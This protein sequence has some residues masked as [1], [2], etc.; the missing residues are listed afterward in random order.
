M[1]EARDVGKDAS[2][3]QSAAATKRRLAGPRDIMVHL[4]GTDE[5]EVRIAHGEAIAAICDAHFSGVYA[6]PL[7]DFGMGVPGDAGAATAAVMLELEERARREG[8]QTF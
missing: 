6:N 3:R 5:D 1:T 2:A 7:P 8:A 4:D